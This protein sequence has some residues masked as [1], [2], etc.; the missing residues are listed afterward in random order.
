MTIKDTIGPTT[1][2]HSA[3]TKVDTNQVVVK[4]KNKQI[5]S[6]TIDTMQLI[7]LKNEN[8]IYQY[9]KEPGK[10]EKIVENESHIWKVIVS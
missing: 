8:N 5:S 4:Q 6:N 10:C 2:K 1:D 7:E 3:T 9:K